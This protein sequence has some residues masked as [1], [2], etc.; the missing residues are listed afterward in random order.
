MQSKKRR[1][2]RTHGY[3]SKKK[4]R[5]GGSRGGRGQ[6]GSMKHHIV[7]SIKTRGIH[8]GKKGFRGRGKKLATINLYQLPNQDKIN[9]KEMGYDKLLGKGTITKAVTITGLCS[10]IA[11]EK[12]EKA[13]GKV[14]K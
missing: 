14:V 2:S 11:K 7:R 1:G 5:G 10:K 9:L 12:I 8:L 13:G 4:H 3:G 6:A